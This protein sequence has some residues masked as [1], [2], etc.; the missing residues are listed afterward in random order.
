MN[1]VGGRMVTHARATT[2][3]P[4]HGWLWVREV[5]PG[6][7]SPGHGRGFVVGSVW[8]G[9]RHERRRYRYIFRLTFRSDTLLAGGH[10][11]LP[12]PYPDFPRGCCP[13]W[14][15]LAGDPHLG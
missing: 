12:V 13:V 14:V 11:V 3:L 2:P 9:T 10:P 1:C 7:A 15:G 4:E 5:V 8:W 6:A